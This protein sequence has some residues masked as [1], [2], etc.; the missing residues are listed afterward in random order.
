[1]RL[2]ERYLF[3]QLLVSVV[4]TTAALTGVAVLTSSL[5]ALDL[6]VNQHQNALIFLEVTLLATPQVV[7]MILPLAML[8]AGLMALNR[9]QTEQEIVICFA[10]GMS[11]WRVASPAIRVASLVAIL[12]LALNLWVQP[13][14]F[15]ELRAVIEAVRG[16]LA[17]VMINPGQF[18]HPAPGLTVYA[19]SLDQSGEIKNLFINKESPSGRSST[20]MA[21]EGRFAK[22]N[23]AP[24][25]IMRGGSYQQLS[26]TG[27]L[28]T[29]SFDENVFDLRPFI[30][31]R[32]PIRYRQSDRYLHELFFPDLRESW[33]AANRNAL[34]AEGHARLA[35]PLYSLAFTALALAAVLGGSFSRIGYGRRIAMASAAALVV[36]VTGFVSAAAS[37]SHPWLNSLQYAAPLACF[38]ICM[39]TVVRQHPARGAGE[40][41]ARLAVGGAA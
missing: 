23:G 4:W 37:A 18:T 3:R 19:Q 7:A 29:M 12:V 41:P 17:A 32:G 11:P 33:D 8:I 36:R 31:G 22:R 30:A 26:Q 27:V 2:L 15:R 34:L 25:L 24:V 6:I 38:A 39:L 20:V 40:V 16:D 35:T 21:S 13:A 5:S 1:M 10:G 28:N 14:C 9:L